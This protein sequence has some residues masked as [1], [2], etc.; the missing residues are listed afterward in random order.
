MLLC[1]CVCVCVCRCPCSLH[2]SSWYSDLQ[3]CDIIK[4]CF[5]LKIIDEVLSKVKFEDGD[6]LALEFSKITKAL[7][8]EL[9]DSDRVNKEQRD[10]I[11][12]EQLKNMWGKNIYYLRIKCYID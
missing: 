9:L 6:Q 1:T 8:V 12:E 3:G 5:S 10:S 2:H 11:N 4:Q 7:R